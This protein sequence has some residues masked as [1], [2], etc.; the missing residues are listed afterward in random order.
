MLEPL[1]VWNLQF[2]CAPVNLSLSTPDRESAQ[3]SSQQQLRKL[4]L[5]GPMARVGDMSNL[6]DLNRAS[7]QRITWGECRHDREQYADEPT[8]FTRLLIRLDAHDL[9]N[10]P[11]HW[12]TVLARFE[13]D[14]SRLHGATSLRLPF[15]W[16]RSR[17]VASVWATY[18]RYLVPMSSCACVPHLHLARHVKRSTIVHMY[19]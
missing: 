4:L 7:Q 12:V 19:P 1:P 2:V 14:E 3:V 6:L 11:G 5:I 13:G 16:R 9:G 15:L 18:P 17:R 8:H 10:A